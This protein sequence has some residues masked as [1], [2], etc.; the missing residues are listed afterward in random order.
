[1]KPGGAG[2]RKGSEF[3]RATCK[4]LSLWVSGG[5]HQDL[6]WRSAMSG[7]RSTFGRKSGKDLS[8][9]AGDISSVSPEG[10]ALTNAFYVECKH[11]RDL[12]TNGFFVRGTG[13]LA[14]FWL[15]TVDEA[16][17]YDRAPMLIAKQNLLPTLLIVESPQL[18]YLGLRRTDVHF[19]IHRPVIPQ[20]KATCSVYQFDEVMSKKFP[21]ALK[22]LTFGYT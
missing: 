14:R 17:S 7:G 12:E 19:P 21:A 9:Q 20:G 15:K 1:M 18:G 16:L 22:A 8:R 6:F 2:K 5:T 11:M 4:A 3:E 10:H 13:Q